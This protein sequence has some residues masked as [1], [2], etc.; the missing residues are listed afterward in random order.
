MGMMKVT[1]KRAYM[2]VPPMSA[3]PWTV[4]Y[5]APPSVGFSRQEYWSGLLFPS[6]GV[7]PNPGIE[8]RSPALY[9]YAL[10]SEPLGKFIGASLVAQMVKRLPVVWETWVRSMGW[11]DPLE[12]EMAI[13]SSTL[14]WRILWTSVVC[15][16]YL[17]F[18]EIIYI[19]K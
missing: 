4:A 7:L 11:E 15:A 6:P 19:L 12:K 2:H 1:L 14:A 17:L 13:H 8:P 16:F 9:A 10:P 3:T 5:H 18:E